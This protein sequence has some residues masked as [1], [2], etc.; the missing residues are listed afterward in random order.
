MFEELIK[1]MIHL[2]RQSVSTEIETDEKSYI[3]KQCP[4][5]DCE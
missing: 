2:D 1:E 5:E 4:P 3:D